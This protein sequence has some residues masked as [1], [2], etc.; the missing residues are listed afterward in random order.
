MKNREN[1]RTGETRGIGELFQEE[2]RYT[3]EKLAAYALDYESQAAP[4]KDY[5]EPVERIALPEPDFRGNPDI[6]KAL[7]RRRSVRDFDA[8]KTMTTGVLSALLWATQGLTARYGQFFFRTAPSAGGLYPVETYLHVRAVESVQPGIYHFRP[9]KFDLEYL[10]KGDSSRYLAGAALGQTLF[11]GA[12]VS[13]IWSAIMARAKWKYRQRAY[14]YV[15]LDA[16]H[17]AENLY[18]AAEALGLG[19]C[20]VGAFYDDEVNSLVGLDGHDET[21][22]YMAA[23]GVPA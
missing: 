18:L 17:I 20:A 2:T 23:V 5:D 15:Y 19:T 1:S 14:R 6:W 12:Q 3:P 13:F 4:Y 9:H 10:R 11:L 8:G 21:A 16:G 7:R 22:I